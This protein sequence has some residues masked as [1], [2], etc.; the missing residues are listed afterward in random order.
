MGTMSL[1]PLVNELEKR[2]LS[3]TFHHGNHP[4]LRNAVDAVEMEVDVA[5]NR[6]PSRADRSRKIDAL[7]AV[8]LGLD[9]QLREPPA[10][11][12]RNYQ[13]LVFGGVRA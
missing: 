11:I 13:L 9:R 7:I 12:A 5:G 6:K 3:K 4:I 2:I 8:L 1:S 10:P